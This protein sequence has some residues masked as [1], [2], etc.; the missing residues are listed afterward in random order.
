MTVTLLLLLDRFF[1]SVIFIKLFVK[2]KIFIIFVHKIPDSKKINNKIFF[3]KNSHE[4][5]INLCKKNIVGEKLLRI[6]SIVKITSH[7]S[8]LFKINLFSC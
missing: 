6:T 2:K 4:N 3:R 1:S 8:F 5:F 7:S